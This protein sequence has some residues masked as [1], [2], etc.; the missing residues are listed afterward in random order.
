MCIKYFYTHIH[1][2]THTHT[3][4][5][6]AINTEAGLSRGARGQLRRPETSGRSTEARTISSFRPAPHFQ[7]GAPQVPTIQ[8]RPPARWPA[9]SCSQLC[10]STD[11]LGGRAAQLTCPNSIA[12]QA[13]WLCPPSCRPP[14]HLAPPIAPGHV[15]FWSQFCG[16]VLSA[17]SIR[18][19]LSVWTP[20]QRLSDRTVSLTARPVTQPRTETF[21][22]FSLKYILWILSLPFVLK[23]FFKKLKYSWVT[24]LR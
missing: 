11:P 10:V 4:S 16:S 20:A 3:P 7:P 12:R 13:G 19:A 17:L 1:T 24:K 2:Y 18:A 5:E 21:Y 14:L 6:G 9:T 8:P 23:M 22:F 15:C